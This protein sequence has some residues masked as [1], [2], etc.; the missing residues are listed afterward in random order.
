MDPGMDG[1]MV[2]GAG[3]IGRVGLEMSMKEQPEPPHPW[4]KPE[5]NLRGDAPNDVS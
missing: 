1:I 3:V 4:E 5:E 2:G